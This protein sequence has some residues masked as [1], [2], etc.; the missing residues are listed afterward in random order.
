MFS[1]VI[2]IYPPHLNFIPRIINNIILSENSTV[3]ISEIILCISEINS[4]ISNKI[5]EAYKELKI[6][7]TISFVSEPKNA[8]Q[9]RNRGW[10]LAKSEYICFLDADDIYH[11]ERFNILKE[12]IEENNYPDAIVGSYLRKCE[13]MNFNKINKPYNIVSSEITF[14]K[15]FPNNLRNESSERGIMGDTNLITDNI[16]ITHGS[17]VI[18]RSIDIRFREDMRWGEDGKIL[19]D[20]LW[21]NPENGVLI[22]N[23]KLMYY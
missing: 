19:R 8:S 6:P 20:I 23:E 15:T 22:T 21:K 18:R 5:T 3:L 2:P 4:E 7:I 11:P 9:N 16:P 1:I 14:Q 17:P 12:I 13:I 10:E